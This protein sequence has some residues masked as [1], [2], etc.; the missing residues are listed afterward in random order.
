MV[1]SPRCRR[2]SL[3]VLRFRLQ[4]DRDVLL[5]AQSVTRV[6]FPLCIMLNGDAA[7]SLAV[8]TSGRYQGKENCRIGIVSPSS[9]GDFLPGILRFEFKY[10][11]TAFSESSEKRYMSCSH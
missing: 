4:F 8:A 2:S 11:L 7:V 1:S 9:D 3:K 6:M 5:M 10:L